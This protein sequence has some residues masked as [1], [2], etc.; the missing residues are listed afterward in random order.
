MSPGFLQ[1]EMVALAFLLVALC[2]TPKQGQPRHGRFRW[3]IPLLIVVIVWVHHQRR[4]G[5]WV[6]ADRPLAIEHLHD[7]MRHLPETPRLV[8]ADGRPA[9]LLTVRLVP[10]RCQARQVSAADLAVGL[11]TIV[12]RLSQ[13]D[14]SGA[15]RDPRGP[16]LRELE[17]TL[18]AADHDHALELR[19]VARLSRQQPLG[20]RDRP[21]RGVQVCAARMN[22][23]VDPLLDEIAAE[24]AAVSRRRQE[25]GE[26]GFT[27]ERSPGSLL[28]RLP[29]RG[30]LLAEAVP[31]ELAHSRPPAAPRRADKPEA[32][33]NA[34]PP[35]RPL[36]L[37]QSIVQALVELA[38]CWS[39]GAT[40]QEVTEAIVTAKRQAA[41]E[42]AKAIAEAAAARSKTVATA[43]HAIA[44]VL[45]EQTPSSAD[46]PGRPA[47]PN[48]DYS[49]GSSARPAWVDAP[50]QQRLDNGKLV[51]TGSTGPFYATP[52]ESQ[53]ALPEVLAALKRNYVELILGPEAAAGIDVACIPK[54]PARIWTG[55]AKRLG[56]L[57]CYETFATLEF[58][59]HDHREFLRLIRDLRS[60]GHALYAAVAGGAVLALL[61]TLL[62]YLKL[63]TLTR[64][65]YSGRLKLAAGA[66]GVVVVTLAAL[67]VAVGIRV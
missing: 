7:R 51:L 34:L 19:D 60:Q 46:V 37:Q 58:D 15:A 44:A 16:A 9:A 57:T 42:A 45:R 59:E 32:P 64:G 5:P 31:E 8:A 54:A 28:I 61:G 55:P 39:R 17:R 47:A 1:L 26:A 4:R 27:I 12:D 23:P 21:I 48:D 10:E 29:S 35:P 56:G 38:G 49:D 22:E 2:R 43:Q 36:D 65:Y 50:P 62:G 24:L 25:T 40:G 63:D 13:Y 14:A 66:I 67:V 52:Q 41:V 30:A 18:I 33:R 11:L 3:W 53:M 6:S 20:S